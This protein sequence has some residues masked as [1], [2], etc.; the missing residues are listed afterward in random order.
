MDSSMTKSN[1]RPNRIS[2]L[3][4]ASQSALWLVCVSLVL[5][6]GSSESA[7][8]NSPSK[9]PAETSPLKTANTNPTD[10]ALASDPADSTSKKPVKAKLASGTN[11]KLTKPSVPEKARPKKRIKPSEPDVNEPEFHEALTTAI[12]EYLRYGMVNA[13][14]L[15]APELCRSVGPTEPRPLMSQSEDDSSH[16]QKLYFLFAKDISHYMGQESTPAPVGQ[17]IV[18]ESWTSIES[19]PNARNLRNH[20]SGNRINPRANV[21]GKTL[22]LGAR[23][24]FFVMTKL[25]K[26]TPKT[27][28]GW[29]YGVVDSDTRKVIS[30]GRVASCMYCHKDANNDRMFG[31]SE[32][33]F[34]QT[35]ISEENGSTGKVPVPP[36][37]KAKDN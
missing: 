32:S 15:P 3:A 7:S 6:C 8:N 2:R 35:I 17:T 1:S 33:I 4:L 5:G 12:D 23:K 20:A 22:E 26:D 16:G 36:Q 10:E 31:P 28:E 19:N 13:I 29:V 9:K 18:K 37:D 30:S 24:N 27:D 25:A 14:A 34:P 21:G 11:S